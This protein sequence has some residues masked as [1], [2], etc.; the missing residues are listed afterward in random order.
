MGFGRIVGGEGLYESDQV[1]N[2]GLEFSRVILD[3]SPNL[4]L[5]QVVSQLFPQREAFL[6]SQLMSFQLSRFLAI[7]HTDLI[8]SLE[9]LLFQMVE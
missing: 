4:S 1:L 6:V 7:F 8:T 3:A 9:K 2:L 5:P